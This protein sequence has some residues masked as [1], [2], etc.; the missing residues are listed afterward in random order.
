MSKFWVSPPSLVPGVPPYRS[1]LGE[2][3]LGGRALKFNPAPSA[4]AQL[5]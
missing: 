3:P 5:L 1:A 2:L 4:H